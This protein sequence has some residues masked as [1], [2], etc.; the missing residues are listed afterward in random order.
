L[1]ACGLAAVPYVGD[2]RPEW[3][4]GLGW[5]LADWRLVPLGRR[6]AG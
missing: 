6:L 4:G 2:W 1:G 5:E 3:G